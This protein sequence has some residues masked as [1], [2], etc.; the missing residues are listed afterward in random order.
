MRILRPTGAWLG[1]LALSVALGAGTSHVLAQ[2]GS[3]GLI[4]IDKEGPQ[5]V[6]V[7]GFSALPIV[8]VVESGPNKGKYELVC[9]GTLIGPQA[10][11]TAAHCF[12]GLDT[13]K[14][15]LVDK[16]KKAVAW[17]LVNDDK[18]DKKNLIGLRCSRHSEYVPGVNEPPDFALCRLDKAINNVRYEWIARSASRLL[19]AQPL[20]VHVMGFG[21]T[22][23][24]ERGKQILD[25]K[26]KLRSA[27]ADLLSAREFI[28]LSNQLYPKLICDGD[29]GGATLL[30]V[31]RQ[32]ELIAARDWTQGTPILVGVNSGLV[33][34]EQRLTLVAS[35]LTR[36]FSG[37][38]DEWLAANPGLRVCDFDRPSAATYDMCRLLK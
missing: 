20:R 4:P 7:A 10:L 24:A 22:S 17:M 38:L 26:I 29:S 16:N 21:C 32:G 18:R 5:T 37:F 35:T 31:D 28:E 2:G 9:T 36:E 1:A 23:Q 3:G 27:P 11:L 12:Y 15:A 13:Q 14:K 6:E 8:N 33:L 34:Q 19:G 30:N 25:A